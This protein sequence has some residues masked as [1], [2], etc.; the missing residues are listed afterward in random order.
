MTTLKK[1]E[2][3]Q[4]MGSGEK[5]FEPNIFNSSKN[6]YF[7]FDHHREVIDVFLPEGTAESERDRCLAAFNNGLL[8]AEGKMV[9]L[10]FSIYEG[11]VQA[12]CTNY[13]C[14]E[15]GK[16]SIP[17]TNL[18]LTFFAV[19]GMVFALEIGSSMHQLVKANKAA[20]RKCNPVSEMENSVNAL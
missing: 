18:N 17:N 2:A 19:E 14:L 7:Y 13:K 6:A 8:D 4:A 9:E 10:V 15:S 3:M 16:F 1:L 11:A 5:V 12:V 20:F